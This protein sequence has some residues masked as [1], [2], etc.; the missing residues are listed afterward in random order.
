M[1]PHITFTTPF[2]PFAE[3][4][5]WFKNWNGDA[6]PVVHQYDRFASAD[7]APSTEVLKAMKGLYT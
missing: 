2:T 6:S 4:G 3:S 1:T 7:L 5:L